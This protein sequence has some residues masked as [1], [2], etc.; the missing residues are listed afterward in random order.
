MACPAPAG[1]KDTDEA[2]GPAGRQQP[3]L[4][5]ADAAQARRTDPALAREQVDEEVLQRDQPAEGE[6]RQRRAVALVGAEHEH[7]GSRP[8]AKYEGSRHGSQDGS[9]RRC[10]GRSWEQ[11]RSEAYLTSLLLQDVVYGEREVRGRV[12]VLSTC[13]VGGSQPWI[14]ERLALYQWMLRLTMRAHGCTCLF[15]SV[16]APEHRS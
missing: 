2:T 8:S 3:G 15:V 16:A 10:A 5:A 6:Q 1:L 13:F 12:P 9:V 11:L 14:G 4:A 7:H